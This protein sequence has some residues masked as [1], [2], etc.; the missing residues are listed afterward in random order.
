MFRSTMTYKGVSYVLNLVEE[1]DC[2]IIPKYN[3]IFI[4]CPITFV[5]NK[6]PKKLT[7]CTKRTCKNVLNYPKASFQCIVGS[8]VFINQIYRN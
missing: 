8:L 2:L 1:K 3:S 5:T 4:T 7:M 6:E